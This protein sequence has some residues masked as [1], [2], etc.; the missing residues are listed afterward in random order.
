MNPGSPNTPMSVY[1]DDAGWDEPH[2]MACGSSALSRSMSTNHNLSLNSRS[3]WRALSAG[4]SP[5]MGR[6]YLPNVPDTFAPVQ[7]L[8]VTPDYAIGPGDE[9]SHPDMGTGDAESAPDSG[10]IGICLRSAGR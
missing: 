10:P 1:R 6:I 9:L 3:W 5:F 7:R 4:L 8:P 2:G